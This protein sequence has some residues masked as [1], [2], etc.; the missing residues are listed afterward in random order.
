MSY[1]TFWVSSC[2]IYGLGNPHF[3]FQFSSYGRRTLFVSSQGCMIPHVPCTGRNPL[4][5]ISWAREFSSYGRESPHVS[6]YG[7]KIFSWTR[8]PHFSSHEQGAPMSH[9]MGGESS[10]VILWAREA[11]CLISWAGSPHV[12]S[13]GW[14]SPRVTWIWEFSSQGRIVLM[15]LIIGIRIFH[16]PSHGQG[17]LISLFIDGGAFMPH[18]MGRTQPP[19]HVP[20]SSIVTS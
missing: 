14:G 5:H 15:S 10:C 20:V 1:F 7:W 17:V 18:L 3:S 8:N 16:V 11:S 12:S 4:R 2:L 13:H 19:Y 9:L 6:Y